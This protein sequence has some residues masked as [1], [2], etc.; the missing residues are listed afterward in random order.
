VASSSPTS[1]E[2]R[3][4]ERTGYGGAGHAGQAV[5]RGVRGRLRV[6]AALRRCSPAAALPGVWAASALLVADRQDVMLVQLAAMVVAFGAARYGSVV[7]V[8]AGSG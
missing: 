8:W 7:S 6:Y 2:G 1:R 5:R 3:P 4:R